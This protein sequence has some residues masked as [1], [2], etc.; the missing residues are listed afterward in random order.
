MGFSDLTV[1]LLAL[2]SK[3]GLVSFHGNMVMWHF[4]MNPSDYDR[5]EFL[6]RLVHGRIGAVRKNSEWRAIRGTG[7]V[8]GRLFGGHFEQI[9]LL[10]GTLYWPNIEEAILFLESTKIPGIAPTWGRQPK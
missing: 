3:V 6:D 4:G 9:S 7:S 5:Q 8:E 10:Y 1:L 2:Y